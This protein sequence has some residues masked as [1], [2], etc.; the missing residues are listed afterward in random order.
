MYRRKRSYGGF[1]NALQETDS[2]FG[3]TLPDAGSS[4]GTEAPAPFTV[5]GLNELVNDALTGDD[6]LQHVLVVGEVS[7]LKI[8]VSG[9]WFFTLVQKDGRRRTSPLR[10]FFGHGPTQGAYTPTKRQD[11]PCRRGCQPLHGGR[12][13]PPC[14]PVPAADRGRS[15]GRSQGAAETAAVCRRIH[16]SRCQAG[17]VETAGPA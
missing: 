13:V 16:G 15:Q 14:R 11:L 17:K 1:A 7:S 10:C 4:G 2:L 9:H 8:S 12:G 3:G 5:R 6:R